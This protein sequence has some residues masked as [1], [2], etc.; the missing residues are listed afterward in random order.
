M[1]VDRNEHQNAIRCNTKNGPIFGEG[2]DLCIRNNSNTTII[3]YSSL[4][5][6]YTHPQY[7]FNSNEAQIFLA[8][9]KLF[10]LDE[11]EVYQKE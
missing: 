3:G 10:Q 8:G 6:T 5:R 4:G 7:A 1:K 9:S 11:I 2:R